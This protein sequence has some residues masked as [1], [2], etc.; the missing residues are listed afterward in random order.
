MSETSKSEDLKDL[1]DLGK[2][3]ELKPG[4]VYVIE[5]QEYR[6]AAALENINWYLR[7]FGRKHNIKFLVLERGLKVSRE[8]SPESGGPLDV[9]RLGSTPQL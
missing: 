4:S 1:A 3:L 8:V 6:S 5:C 2:A 9:N 7:E